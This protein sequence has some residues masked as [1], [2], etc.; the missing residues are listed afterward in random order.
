MH[1]IPIGRRVKIL[2]NN[3]SLANL[4]KGDIV[5]VTDH[6]GIDWY[7]VASDGCKKDKWAV[8]ESQI[9]QLIEMEENE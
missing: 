4:K 2:V 7:T 1:K 5:R 8:K 3:P 9:S 6:M